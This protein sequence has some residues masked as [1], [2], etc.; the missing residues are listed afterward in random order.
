MLGPS[1][2]AHNPLVEP[3]AVSDWFVVNDGVMGGVS[4]NRIRPASDDAAIFEGHLSLENNGGFASVR[5]RIN[6]VLSQKPRR[7]F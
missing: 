3:D 1:R 4:S 6:E 5:A 7:L 2:T